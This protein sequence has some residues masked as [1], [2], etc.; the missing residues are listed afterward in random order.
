MFLN[1]STSLR[2]VHSSPG[3]RRDQELRLR[4]HRRRSRA[5]Q[6]QRN[7]QRAERVQPQWI[8][9]QGSG[10]RLRMPILLIQGHMCLSHFKN[11]K[12]FFNLDV[13]IRSS[14]KAR[15]GR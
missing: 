6:N 9:H 7:R 13:N 3:S 8:K 10:A 11:M 5:S 15:Y 14:T 12:L 1:F 4:P 2:R